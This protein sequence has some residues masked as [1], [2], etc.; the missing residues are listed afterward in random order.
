MA[1]DISRF[2]GRFVEEARD[3]L[4]RLDDGLAH[5]VADPGDTES[6]NALFRSAHTIKGSS[7]MLRLAAITETAHKMEDLLGALREGTLALDG[8]L[9]R[10]LRRG[11]DALAALVDALADGRPPGEADP[12]L[13]E[14]LAHPLKAPVASDPTPPAAPGPAAEAGPAARAAAPEE[15]AAPP[16]P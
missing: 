14:A 7:R 11:L 10:V 3:H 1:L 12:A 8:P 2:T 16:S 4:S 15:E 5:L 9:E 6:L 13:L